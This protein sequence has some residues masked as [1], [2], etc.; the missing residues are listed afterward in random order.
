[1]WGGE[2]PGRKKKKSL[3]D[4]APSPHETEAGRL[5]REAT[6][7]G[8]KSG[9][10]TG[11]QGIGGIVKHN[12]TLHLKKRV[13][14]SAAPSRAKK[15]TTKMSGPRTIGLPGATSEQTLEFKT[16]GGQES[17]SGTLTF[18]ASYAT[19]RGGP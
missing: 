14:E 16:P 7:A 2:K 18:N 3:G 9:G 13:A 8:P 19:F 5:G 10:V 4:G 12:R 17:K 11:R 15:K 6:G 1:V